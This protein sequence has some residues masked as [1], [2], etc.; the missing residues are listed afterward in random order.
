MRKR[1]KTISNF[2]DFL[3]LNTQVMGIAFA[4]KKQRVTPT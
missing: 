2:R 3:C 1:P 4:G